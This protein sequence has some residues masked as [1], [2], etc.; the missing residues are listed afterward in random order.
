[1]SVVSSIRSSEDENVVEVVVTNNAGQV[2]TF[3]YDKK[4]EANMIGFEHAGFVFSIEQWTFF[5]EEVGRL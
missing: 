3:S 2:L 1:M 4:L 5:K